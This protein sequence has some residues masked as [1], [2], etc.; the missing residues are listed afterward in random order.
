MFDDPVP[1]LLS[2]LDGAG[3]ARRALMAAG[4]VPWAGA[5][6]VRYR[7]EIDGAVLE[8]AALDRA[9]GEL[10]ALAGCRA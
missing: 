4:A 8:A 10:V 3:R 6:A 5:V 2:A 7:A 9:V 1:L